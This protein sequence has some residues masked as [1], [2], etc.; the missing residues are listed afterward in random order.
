MSQRNFVVC[1]FVFLFFFNSEAL[2]LNVII[3]KHVSRLK[4]CYCLLFI[5]FLFISLGFLMKLMI[6]MYIFLEAYWAEAGNVC[7]WLFDHF[8]SYFF[9]SLSPTNAPKYRT[10]ASAD[11]RLS[12]KKPRK[13]KCSNNICF[14]LNNEQNLFEQMQM[15]YFQQV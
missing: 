14:L 7:F 1:M 9:V 12:N 5:L 3:F 13:A 2:L 6:N 4:T 11:Q 15:A 10:Q 8:H